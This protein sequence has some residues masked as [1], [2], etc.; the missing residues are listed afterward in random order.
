MR[1]EVW[2]LEFGVWGLRFGFSGFGSSLVWGSG[3]RVSIADSYY[4]QEG[5]EGAM[6]LVGLSEYGTCKTCATNQPAQ[7]VE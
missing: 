1:F 7:I 3:F 5:T 2:G 4:V 6:R